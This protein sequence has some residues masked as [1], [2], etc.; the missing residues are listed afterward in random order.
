MLN[1]IS[2]ITPSTEG[3]SRPGGNTSVQKSSLSAYSSSSNV[4]DSIVYS[5]ALVFLSKLKWQLKKMSKTK[6]GAIYIDLVFDNYEFTTS[7]DIS[8]KG[9]NSF[10]DYQI[11]N[12]ILGTESKQKLELG[13]SV[14]ANDIKNEISDSSSKLIYIPLMY[15]RFFLLNINSEIS[16]KDTNLTK[17]IDGIF[18][19][20]YK[21]LNEITNKIA[22]FV[23]K[24]TGEVVFIPQLTRDSSGNELEI[25][26][27]KR[28]NAATTS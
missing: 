14:R 13:I 23:E 25:K 3:F 20:L 10:F 6:T 22:V 15:E 21:E 4:S 26:G 17:L 9:K 2:H 7:V 1:K 16:D 18:E 11:R 5:A 27:I 19:D 12:L 28:I 8:T 24:L